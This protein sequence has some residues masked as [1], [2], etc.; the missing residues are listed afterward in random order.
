MLLKKGLNDYRKGAIGALIDEYERAALEVKTIVQSVSE[1]NYI[2][3]ADA[4]TQNED[5]RSIQTIVSHVIRAGFSYANYIR[6]SLSMTGSPVEDKKITYL[7]ISSEMDR[8][9]A[10]TVEIFDGKWEIMD[11]QITNSI[12]TARWG[13]IYNIDQLLEHA[14]VHVLKHR[15]QIEKF[16][17][18]FET[19]F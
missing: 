7:E 17:L 4:E 6:E 10:Y 15:R 18:K 9:L 13:V 11:E 1:E 2:C 5:C 12:I 19:E 3:I 8:M 14:I 16:L